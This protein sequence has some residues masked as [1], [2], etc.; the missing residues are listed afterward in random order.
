MSLVD[1]TKDVPKSNRIKSNYFM[2]EAKKEQ[3]L[4]RILA[5]KEGLELLSQYYLKLNPEQDYHFVRI[6]KVDKGELNELEHYP[7]EYRIF[8][9]EVGQIYIAECGCFK[10][11]ASLPNKPQDSCLWI[12][13]DNEWNN[14]NLRILVHTDDPDIYHQ[15][16][17]IS[18][19]PFE[20]HLLG[21]DF[22]HLGFLDIVEEKVDEI[23]CNHNLKR[24]KT[25]I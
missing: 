7:I 21:Y 10:I 4:N 19:K 5:I 1:K 18:T 25:Q 14:E 23:L 17:N 11:E 3:F 8:L 12:L 6:K 2:E 22:S 20:R 15:I 9:E 24:L 16:F 13:E